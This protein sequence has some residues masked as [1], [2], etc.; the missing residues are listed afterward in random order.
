MRRVGSTL[1]GMSRREEAVHWFVRSESGELS[2]QE[3]AEFQDWIADPDHAAEYAKVQ[4]S[5]ATLNA[6]TDD[7]HVEALRRAALAV[8][9]RPNRARIAAVACVTLAV[10]VVTGMV[11]WQRL[12]TYQRVQTVQQTPSPRLDMRGAAD[13]ATAPGER[14]Q[15]TLPD[16]SRLTINTDTA[17][18]VAF[19]ADERV[20]FVEKGQAYFEVAKDAARPFVVHS[21][22]RRVTALGTAFEV[23]LDRSRFHVLLVEGSVKVES[24]AERGAGPVVRAP[25]VVLSPGQALVAPMG[26]AEHVRTMNVE[27][28]LRWRDGFVEFEDERLDLAV[29]EMNRYFAEPIIVRDDTVADLRLSGVFTIASREEFLELVTELLPLRVARNPGAYVELVSAP[30]PGP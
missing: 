2:A 18:D 27:R 25:D 1:R 10:C 3:R 24:A 11:A 20:V 7:P 14:L 12:G 21:A 6:A 30:P 5:V 4:R 19:S 23:R 26:V 15:V 13:Y 16:G 9:R 28:E 22:G 8:G 17:I 29:A